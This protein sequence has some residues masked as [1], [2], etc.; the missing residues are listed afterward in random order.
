MSEKAAV[1][2]ANAVDLS[3]NIGF[4]ARSRGNEYPTA[5]Q[6]E[7]LMS[8]SFAPLHEKFVIIG[9]FSSNNYHLV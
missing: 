8:Q 4:H 3:T 1:L 7:R 9:P 2:D 5:T 6:L